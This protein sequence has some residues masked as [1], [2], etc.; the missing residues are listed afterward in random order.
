MERSWDAVKAAA[1]ASDQTKAAFDELTARFQEVAAAH[2]R[3]ARMG[4]WRA[5]SGR[6]EAIRSGRAIVEAAGGQ[7]PRLQI[8]DLE[9]P[10]GVRSRTMGSRRSMG[11]GRGAADARLA[12][13]V[14]SRC[15][16]QRRPWTM[17]SQ[18]AST[19]AA[20]HR[21]GDWLSGIVWL[22][23]RAGSRLTGTKRSVIFSRSQ[24]ARSDG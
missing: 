19:Q 18:A 16:M 12:S 17:T 4:S 5:T 20:C 8:Q 7:G 3:L 2:E 24:R 9:S 1:S 14:S 11:A 22:N 10:S 23:R 13:L 6:F 15:L 21:H